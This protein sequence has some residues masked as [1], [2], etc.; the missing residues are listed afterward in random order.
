MLVTW[1]PEPILF[2]WKFIAIRWYGIFFAFAFISGGIIGNWI[3]KRESKDPES[4]DRIM[5]HMI[6][7]TL[8]GARLGHCLFYDPVYY[9]SNPF[10]I[11]KIWEGGLASHGAL[12]GIV[13]AMYLYS[14]KTPD[15][16]FSWIMDRVGITAG[17][18]SGFIRLGNLFNS[19][20]IGKPTGSDWGFIFL[21]IDNIPR[22]P[23]QLYEAGAYFLSFLAVLFFYLK[24]DFANKPGFLIGLTFATLLPARFF[25]EYFKEIQS[26]FEKGW[27][28]NLGQLLSIPFFLLGVFLMLKAL[29]ER[30]SRS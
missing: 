30:P 14:R 6:I 16:T 24:K 22:H 23:T 8:V 18:G 13:L 15:Q 1:N 26:I 11:I 21:R 25:I 2:S 27:V 4:L 29:K 7:G 17:I 5:V 28:L 19:E 9:L 20:I 12:I 3:L 10:E